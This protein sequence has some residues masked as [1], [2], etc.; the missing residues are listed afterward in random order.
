MKAP[1]TTYLQVL[2]PVATASFVSRSLY[3]WLMP[4]LWS[5]RKKTLTIDDCG[6]IPE[7]LSAHS[8]RAAIQDALSTTG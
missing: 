2:A 3:F 7:S 5:G 8:T 1:L 6:M 4:L